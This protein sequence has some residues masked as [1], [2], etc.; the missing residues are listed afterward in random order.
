MQSIGVGWCGDVI[1]PELELVSGWKLV[2]WPPSF[3]V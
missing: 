2:D 1:D 3:L